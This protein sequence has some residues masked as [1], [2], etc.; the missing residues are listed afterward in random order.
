MFYSYL[1]KKWIKRCMHC[2]IALMRWKTSIEIV[3]IDRQNFWYNEFLKKYFIIA[4][5]FHEIRS[6]C[7]Y[8]INISCKAYMK[9]Q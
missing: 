1:K 3:Y 6:E 5:E 2:R 7:G 4:K 9:F 8:W